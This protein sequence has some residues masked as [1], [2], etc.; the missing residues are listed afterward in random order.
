MV[1]R[2]VFFVKNA[3][4]PFDLIY[5][6]K[7]EVLYYKITIKCTFFFCLIKFK[8]FQTAHQYRVKANAF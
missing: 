1:A 4:F 2:G 8:P 3:T 7:S 6:Y 5:E